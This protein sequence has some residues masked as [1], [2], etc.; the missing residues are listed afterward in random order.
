MGTIEI[1]KVERKVTGH[2]HPGRPEQEICL[3]GF[4]H[5]TGRHTEHS[6]VQRADWR[7]T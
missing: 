3:Q 4:R 2:R 6:A 5:A 1:K 7:G